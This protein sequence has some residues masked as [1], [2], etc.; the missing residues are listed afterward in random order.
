MEREI[1]AQHRRLRGL[2]ADVEEA[3]ASALAPAPGDG[4]DVDGVREALAHLSE[5][6]DVHFSQEDRLY[7]PLIASL[8]PEHREQIASLAEQHTEF[9]ERVA[10]IVQE[11]A[12]GRLEATGRAF[13]AFVADFGRHEKV[14]EN[15]LATLER[16]V[17]A[18]R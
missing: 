12:V 14:E 10:R 6:M 2:F 13:R 8:R 11:L 1:L 3:L 16:D 17:S 5:A 4:A 9:R 7:Y 18:A 15:L